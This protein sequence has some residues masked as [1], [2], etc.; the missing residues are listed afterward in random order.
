MRW[1]HKFFGSE[2]SAPVHDGEWRYEAETP[3]QQANWHYFEEGSTAV[4]EI[5]RKFGISEQASCRWKMPVGAMGMVEIGQGR[6]MP[7]PSGGR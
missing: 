4:V 1:E 2:I 6:T 3:Q 7:S 5:C